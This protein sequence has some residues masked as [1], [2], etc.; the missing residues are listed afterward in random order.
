MLAMLIVAGVSS[1]AGAQSVD[2]V[3]FEMSNLLEFQSGRNFTT[4]EVDRERFFN[5]FILDVYPGNDV[6]LGLRFEVYR[7]SPPPEL[8]GFPTA[9][10]EYNLLS[11]RFVEWSGTYATGR[12]GNG[13]TIFGSGLVLRA[14]ELPGVVRQSMFPTVSYTES[15]DIDGAFVDAWYGPFE[16]KLVHGQPVIDPEIP[17][18]Q[19]NRDRRGG[20]VTGGWGRMR[21]LDWFAVGGSFLHTDAIEPGVTTSSRE[22]FG[23]LEAELDPV[24]LLQ[25]LVDIPV[26]LTAS[27]EYASRSWKPLDDGI[28][29]QTGEPHALYT[30]TQLAWS[31][32]AVGFETKDYHRF[33]SSVNDPPTLVP[34]LSHRLL[35]RTT[36][37]LDPND[38]KGHQL[39]LGQSLPW[40]LGGGSLEAVHAASTGRREV[41]GEFVDPRDYDQAFVAVDSDPRRAA[42]LRLYFSDGKDEFEDLTGLRTAGGLASVAFTENLAAELDIGH[43]V[44]ERIL[45]DDTIRSEDWAVVGTFSWANLGS[46]GFLF[47]RTDDPLFLDD[48]FTPEIETDPRSYFGGSLSWRAGER[49]DVILFAGRRRGGTACTSGT[50]YFVPDFEGLELRVSSRF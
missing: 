3:R 12:V 26:I 21:P 25:P 23:S 36:H 33:R 43:Q 37:V 47:E 49:H 15:R 14:F 41:L 16:V 34:E 6:R 50:C 27:A 2:G 42:R 7:D 48:P 9:E 45:F 5:Q 13:Y 46:V 1:A 32:G 40:W 20:S 11:Q 19:A 22:D 18:E 30:S 24:S 39:S 4:E 31:S 29:T 17:P 35:N 10:Y 8:F 44:R 28:S 38:E